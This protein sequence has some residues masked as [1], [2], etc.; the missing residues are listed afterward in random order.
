MPHPP[1]T[2]LALYA[3]DT[4]IITQSWRTDTIVHRLTNAMSML[5]RYFSKWKLQVNTHKT[6]AILFTRRR[7]IAPAPLCFHSSVVPWKSQV[8]YL[9]LILDSKLLF[10]KHINS[11]THKATGTFLQLFPLLARDSTLTTHNKLILYKLFTRSALTYAAPVWSY[12]SPSTYRRLQVLQ[13][14]CL[15]VIGNYPRCTPIP[16]LHTTLNIPPIRD[17]VYHLTDKFFS[18]CP[19][20]LNPLISA[21]GN[22]TLADLQHQYKKYIHK[23]P[24]HILL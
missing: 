3:D 19:A 23:R 20:H 1:H 4:A 24:K 12:I 9:G 21:I 2:L 18:S 7:P 5:L 11:V 22:Y 14:K 15:R 13:S 16:R 8:R 10:T 6:E 17:F